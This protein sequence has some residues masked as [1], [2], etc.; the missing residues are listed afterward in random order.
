[1]PIPNVII[2]AILLRSGSCKP[3]TIGIGRIRT[4]RSVQRLM[5]PA[6]VYAASKSPQTPFEIDLSQLNAKG[7]QSKNSSKTTETHHITTRHMTT[8]A[9]VRNFLTEKILTYRRRSE[10]LTDTR[11]LDHNNTVGIK[12]CNVLEIREQRLCRRSRPSDKQ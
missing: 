6:A 2:R 1:M 7:L 5:T 3:K 8:Y 9:A 10:I 11:A 12:F 4:I